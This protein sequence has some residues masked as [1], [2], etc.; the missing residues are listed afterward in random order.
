MVTAKTRAA[1]ESLMPWAAV[2]PAR[3]GRATAYLCVDH[4][5]RQPVQHPAE[6][7]ALLDA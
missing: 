3:D 6:L 2:L 5:C 1:L 7:A 4:A